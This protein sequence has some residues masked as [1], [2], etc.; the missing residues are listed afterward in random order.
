[1]FDSTPFYWIFLGFMEVEHCGKMW[2]NCFTI[3]IDFGV[4]MMPGNMGY[5]VSS[6]DLFRLILD[7]NFGF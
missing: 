7:K 1:M 3:E 2:C 5:P 6:S 4:V